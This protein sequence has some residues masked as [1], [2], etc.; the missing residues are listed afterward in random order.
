MIILADTSIWIDHW[1]RRDARFDQLLGDGAVLTHPCVIG[2]L[3]LGHIPDRER[4]L[5][6]L[7]LLPSVTEAAHGEVM[8]LIER[9]RL[10]GSGIGWDDAD[11]LASA[12]ISRVKLWTKDRRLMT[13]ADAVGWGF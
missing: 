11:L 9:R 4:T 12:M 13:V 10:W 7:R 8:A 2:E 5:G 6:Y 1:H 3:A